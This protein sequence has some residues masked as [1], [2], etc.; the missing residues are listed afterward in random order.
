MALDDPHPTSSDKPA[1]VHAA[2]AEASLHP[3]A[4][5]LAGAELLP[6]GRPL[7]HA[8]QQAR[9]AAG[10]ADPHSSRCPHCR[11]AIEGLTALDRATRALRAEEQPDGHSLA[12]RVINAVRSEVRLGTKLLLDDPDHD[13]RIAESAAAKVLRRAADTVPGI[14]AASCR[15]AAAKDDHAVHVV[16]VVVITVAATLDQPLRGRAEAVRQAVLHAA[17]HVLG[18]AVTTV[19]VEVNAVLGA[20]RVHGDER[21][22]LSER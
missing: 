3:D 22:E 5:L 17:E 13:L 4:E 20:S 9:S 14:R 12:T 19:D 11:E 1:G 15:V 6:C 10:A 7:G 8:W 2:A 16:H 18:L 21:H